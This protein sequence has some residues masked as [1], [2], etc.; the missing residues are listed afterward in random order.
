MPIPAV[1]NPH[2]CDFMNLEDS[3]D[4]SHAR[5]TGRDPKRLLRNRFSWKVQYRL[6]SS[7]PRHDWRGILL[8]AN[9]L[10]LSENCKNKEDVKWQRP[11]IIIGR[12]VRKGPLAYYRCNSIEVDLNDLRPAD[13]I[14]DVVGGDGA[15]RF[16]FN[17]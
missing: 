4:T 1:D 6:K 9:C 3:A 7:G 12:F 14:F 5:E 16:P 15:L 10:L 11:G 2:F 17:G 13:K 8:T